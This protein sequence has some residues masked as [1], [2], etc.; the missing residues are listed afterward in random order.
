DLGISEFPSHSR[1]YGCILSAGGVTQHLRRRPSLLSEF[2]P[3]SERNTQRRGGNDHRS[4]YLLEV[5][6]QAEALYSDSKRPRLDLLHHPLLRHPSLLSH[7][8]LTGVEELLK[9]HCA[10]GP[11]VALSHRPELGIEGLPAGLSKEELIQS[12]DRVDRE[13]TMT[14]QQIAKLKKKQQ[15]LEAETT[16]PAEAENPVSPPPIEQRH[17]NLVQIIYDENR[18]KAEAAHRTLQGLGPRIELPLYNQ[19]SDTQQYHENIQIHQT[20]TDEL[21]IRAERLDEAEGKILAKRNTAS[22]AEACWQSL[23]NQPDVCQIS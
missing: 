10:K 13:I 11:S 2:Q 23:E 3:G 21:Q 12:M 7:G 19:P 18:K 20:H 17:C 1:D 22:A 5:S 15:Q 6:D 8:P 4:S 9:E 16:K 14:E